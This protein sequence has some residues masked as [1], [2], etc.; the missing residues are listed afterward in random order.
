MSKSPPSLWSKA[1]SAAAVAGLAFLFLISGSSLVDAQVKAPKAKAGS[2]AKKDAGSAKKD[3]GSA[4]SS[5]KVGEKFPSLKLKDQDGEAFDL[6]KTLKNGPV[7]LV[8]FR[9]ADW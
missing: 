2:S 8:I 4:G 3:A 7:A 5:I 1:A 6:E 9:S